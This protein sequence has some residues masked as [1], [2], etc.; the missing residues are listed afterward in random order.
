MK[1]HTSIALVAAC[2][3][4]NLHAAC[5]EFD[6]ALRVGTVNHSSLTEISGI[7]ASRQT[8]GVIWAHDDSGDVN[9]VFALSTSGAHLGT[10]YF[11]GVTAVD[12]EDMAIGPGP[13]AGA[14]YLFMADTG[15]NALTRSTVTIY[16]IA[17]PSLAN[18]TAPAEVTLSG[19][20]AFPVRYPDGNRDAETILVD[21][22]NGDIVLLT[23]DR[24][25]TGITY[26]YV[27]PV[28]EQ[29]PGQV[30]TL[31]YV[32]SIVSSVEIKGGDV[33]P[34]G[35]CAILRRHSTT[36]KADGWLYFRAAGTRLHEVFATTPCPVPLPSEPQGEAVTFSPDG[37]GY[38]TISEGVSQPIYYHGPLTAPAAP[39][40]GAISSPSSTQLTIS[41]SDVANNEAVYEVA[42][43]SDGVAFQSLAT[44]GANISSFADS[45]LTPDTSYTYQIVAVNNAGT[46][47]ALVVSGRTQPPAPAVP[48]APADLTGR[49][50]SKSQVT[51][52]WTDTSAVESGFKIERSTDGTRYTQI[53]TVGANVVSYT[54]SGLAGGKKYYYRVRAYNNGGSSPYSNVVMVQTPKK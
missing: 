52:T 51:L 38:Y 40:N 5:P 39:E 17:E 24:S 3:A 25:L 19:A 23:R 50:L 35:S 44:L 7:A 4:A 10:Y 33:S 18:V 32:G 36:T 49:A 42:R 8:P 47:A 34:D 21:P 11:G 41:W 1:V 16:R 9:R 53:A 6:P 28:E 46:S 22:I 30:V 20:E 27:Y 13:M 43:S 12:W 29:A 37:A 48:T 54:N 15:N 2:L 45:G 31:T 26:V 14:D